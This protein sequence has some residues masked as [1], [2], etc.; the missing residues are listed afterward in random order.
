MGSKKCHC[1]S[2]TDRDLRKLAS[3]TVVE[4]LIPK[5]VYG[6]EFVTTI[7]WSKDFSAP[8]DGTDLVQPFQ[9]SL[10]C[11]MERIPFHPRSQTRHG[12]EGEFAKLCTAATMYAF[13]FP[14]LE[15]PREVDS[16]EDRETLRNAWKS[17]KCRQLCTGMNGGE[18]EGINTFSATDIICTLEDA[19]EPTLKAFFTTQRIIKLNSLHPHPPPLLSRRKGNLCHLASRTPLLFTE[20]YYS[21]P[22][23]MSLLRFCYEP[24]EKQCPERTSLFLKFTADGSS[25]DLVARR[26][27]L[28]SDSQHDFAAYLR[29]ARRPVSD[30]EGLSKLLRQDGDFDFPI[31]RKKH[32]EDLFDIAGHTK[33][34]GWSL[35]SER[36]KQSPK[37]GYDE[38]GQRVRA[39]RCARDP[40]EM[41]GCENLALQE[42]TKS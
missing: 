19:H 35:D 22:S 34:G 21:L 12:V 37:T 9:P 17:S 30:H 7:T 18:T 14:V 41:F 26:L 32:S 31:K 29:D 39:V 10:I 1:K 6:V 42:Q 11:R 16:D 38:L 36:T 40:K 23:S 33:D 15:R 27:R 25:D 20:R 8:G 13:L 4:F 24:Q 28:R 2:T 3:A 5:N